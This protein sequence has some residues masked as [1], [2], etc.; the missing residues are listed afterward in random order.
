MAG[1]LRGSVDLDSA[2]VKSQLWDMSE[3]QLDRAVCETHLDPTLVHVIHS[4]VDPLTAQTCGLLD[5]ASLWRP[6]QAHICGYSWVPLNVHF[7]SL[8][9]HACTG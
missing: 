4:S 2:E 3:P 8:P 6:V 5:Q 1:Q 7:R 9:M